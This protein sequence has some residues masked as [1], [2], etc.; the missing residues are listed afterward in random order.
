M[1]CTPDQANASSN[2]Q[3][4]NNVQYV[5]LIF[6]SASATGVAQAKNRRPTGLAGLVDAARTPRTPARR[7]RRYKNVAR[8]RP[9]MHA[10]TQRTAPRAPGLPLLDL[11][12]RAL[13]HAA[14]VPDPRVRR[15]S[16]ALAAVNV[17]V[18]AR[19]GGRVGGCD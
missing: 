11:A 17:A 3:G 15:M 6:Y 9:H 14:A 16:A 5:I 7:A 4:Q 18:A 12:A 19:G 13:N 1:Q 2:W 10:C 8:P